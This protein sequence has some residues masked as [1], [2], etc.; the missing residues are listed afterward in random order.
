[1]SLTDHELAAITVAERT[2]SILSVIG[3]TVVIGTFLSSQAFRKPINRVV[4][5]A[6]WANILTNVGTLISR[7]AIVRGE[8]ATTLC[9]FQAFI[10][11]WLTSERWCRFMPADALWTFAMAFNVYLT[12]FHKYDASSLRNLEWKYLVL[13]YGLPFIPPFVYFFVSTSSKGPIYGSATLWCWVSIDWDILRI[14]VFYGPVWSVILLT[15]AIYAHVGID[16][17]RKRRLLRSFNNDVRLETR[18]NKFFE[19]HASK[20]VH[21]TSEAANS[22]SNGHINSNSS[23]TSMNEQVVGKPEGRISLGHYPAYSVTVERGEDIPEPPSA[24]SE[25]RSSSFQFSSGSRRLPRTEVNPVNS[26]A[27]A[28]CKYAML[29][30]IALLVTWVPSTINRVYSLVYP[31]DANFGLEFV[32]AFVLPLQGFW[33]SIIYVAVSWSTIMDFARRWR[34]HR[35]PKESSCRVNTAMKLKR[36]VARES[37][38]RYHDA[39]GLG[40]PQ[41]SAASGDTESTTQLAR[42]DAGV[43]GQQQQQQQQQ[44]PPAASPSPPPP[45]PIPLTPGPR[46]TRLQ[47]IY[48]KALRATLKSNSYENFAACFPTPAR[49]VPASLE[50]VHRQ[51][52]AKLEEGATAEFNDIIKERDVIKGLNELDRLVGE[53]RRR[54]SQGESE[55]AVPPHMLNADDLYRAHLTPY[56]QQAESALNAKLEEAQ[57]Q[58]AA[59]AERVIAQRQEIESLLSGLEAVMADLEGSAKTST[60]YSKAHSLRQESLLIDEEV[61]KAD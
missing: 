32:S 1:M 61:R 20:V 4:F 41:H 47:D 7:S 24:T 40:G 42:D 58:N 38:R 13:C 44:A 12:F 19:I 11:Q 48:S 28:Y 35:P 10:I 9:R 51:L 45:A 25:A 56:L 14:A 43:E 30:F 57:S 33:N 39:A 18:L 49:H 5:Y 27:F 37:I 2:N 55:T 23:S 16:I 22:H 26:A 17:A 46:A 50:S 15:F 21:I 59:L 31:K 54:K 52:N 60:Q 6:S 53:A 29:Y 8:K 34:A 3:T 36:F